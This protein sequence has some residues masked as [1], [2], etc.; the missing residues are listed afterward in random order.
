MTPEDEFIRQL[1]HYF[2]ESEPMSEH[3]REI[4]KTLLKTYGDAL[5]KP[6]AMMLREK[7]M[8]KRLVKEL[9]I[10]DTNERLVKVEDI[11]DI[12][13]KI[14]GVSR[15]DIIGECR[16]REYVSAR[17]LCLFFIRNYFPEI[18][19]H[20]IGLMFGNKKGMDHTTVIHARKKIKDL[21][22]TG[23]YYFTQNVRAIEAQITSINS[24]NKLSKA[25]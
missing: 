16:K 10:C 1:E 22:E 11:F 13:I 3:S 7:T 4:V 8:Y 15:V 23:D 25:V 18:S 2:F 20:D 14:T 21:L 5:P 6:P 19:L 24:G 9:A 17:H 12:V